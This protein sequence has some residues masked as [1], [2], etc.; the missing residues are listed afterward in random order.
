[1]PEDTR[2]VR[3]KVRRRALQYVEP[4]VR[5]ERRKFGGAPQSLGEVG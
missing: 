2:R 4:F 5:A 3:D 1:M